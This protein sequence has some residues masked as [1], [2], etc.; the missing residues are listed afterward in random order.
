M[1]ISNDTHLDFMSDS[2][3]PKQPAALS[4]DPGEHLPYFS[5]ASRRTTLDMALYLAR[6][7]DLVLLIHGPVNSGKTALLREMIARGGP[8]IHAV[9][10]SAERALTTQSICD[11]LLGSFKLITMQPAPEQPLVQIKEQLDLLQRKG[12]HCILFIDDADQLTNDAYPL[13]EALADLRGEAGRSLLNLVLFAQQREKITLLGPSV[14]HR[15]K[16][17]A[18]EPL[19]AD[20]VAAYVQHVQRNLHADGGAV[21]FQVRDIRRIARASSRWPGNINTIIQQRSGRAAPRAKP[22]AQPRHA[23]RTTPRYLLGAAL[24]A[25]ALILVF[26]F[27][28]SINR[29]FE[30]P[31]ATP[32]VVTAPPQVQAPVPTVAVAVKAPEE[33]APSIALDE[34]IAPTPEPEPPAAPVASVAPVEPVPTPPPPPPPPTAPKKT[35]KPQRHA[36]LLAQSPNAYTLQIIGSSQE[37][38]IHRTLKKIG[39]THRTAVFRGSRNGRP[40]FGLVTGVYPDFASAY[41]ARTALPEELMRGAWVRRLNSVQDE[42]NKPP[43]TESVEH[44]TG[45]PTTT[46]P[47]ATRPTR[48]P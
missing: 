2:P 25:A 46:S 31:T 28:D 30:T 13:L 22:A 7:S 33:P 32:P 4:G 17:T 19:A 14:R 27:Q 10:V 12:Y 38:D 1:Q 45:T 5:A 18:L 41:Q 29:R 35:T 20:E 23:L 48:Q 42:I 37:D 47:P 39:P 36:W 34:V 11:A 15:V 26:V 8:N 6:Y 40:W 43:E 44:A 3:S 16:A 21:V 24:I 9:T